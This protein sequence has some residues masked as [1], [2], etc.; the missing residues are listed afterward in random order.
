MNAE[1]NPST[2]PVVI[3]QPKS[4]TGW[5]PATTKEAKATMVVIAV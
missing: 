3:I 2:M 5:S 4:M 1:Q